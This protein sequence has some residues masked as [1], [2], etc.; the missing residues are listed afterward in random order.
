MR[1]D[2]AYAHLPHN[3]VVGFICDDADVAPLSPVH[4]FHWIRALLLQLVREA[5]LEGTAGG[6]IRLPGRFDDGYDGGKEEHEIQ[7]FVPEHSIH[8][9]ADVDL[10]R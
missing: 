6:V 5:V 2:G 4:D 1:L 10:G 9:H 8:I 7:L 3:P